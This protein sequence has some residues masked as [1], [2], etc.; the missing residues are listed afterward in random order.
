VKKKT[1]AQLQREID[2]AVGGES[3]WGSVSIPDIPPSGG[4]TMTVDGTSVRVIPAAI[5]T[6][7][8]PYDMQFARAAKRGQDDAW[9]VVAPSGHVLGC[10]IGLGRHWSIYR[11][12]GG[13]PWLVDQEAEL[14]YKRGVEGDWR[15]A[16]SG[17]VKLEY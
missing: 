15:R 6:T 14:T 16:V 13:A 3:G 12:S 2:A 1:P 5:R 10:M 8:D 9:L 17:I 11:R 4:T 7:R